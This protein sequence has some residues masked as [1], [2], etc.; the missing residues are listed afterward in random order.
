MDKVLE[1][2]FQLLSLFYLTIGRNQEAP[3]TYALTSTI[4]RL[5]DHLREAD[6]FSAK[7]LQSISTTLS[8]LGKNITVASNGDG[9]EHTDHSPYLITLLT[10]RVELCHSVLDSLRMRLDR[11]PDPLLEKHEKLVSILR[12]I[13]LANTKSKVK[14]EA[15][16][17]AWHG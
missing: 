16:E 11:I 17:C 2:C 5:L 6:L 8:S 1:S 7:D 4:K 14:N 15:A 12:C 13:S 10:K 9:P 3:A